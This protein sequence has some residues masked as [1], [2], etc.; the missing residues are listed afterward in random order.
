MTY[1]EAESKASL[2]LEATVDDC[3]TS[4]HTYRA[5]AHDFIKAL[6]ANKLKIVEE[7]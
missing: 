1:T 5:M 4:P 3:L 6:K 7:K 2:L